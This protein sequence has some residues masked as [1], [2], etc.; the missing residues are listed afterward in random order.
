MGY[1]GGLP[2]PNK[3]RYLI[4]L[5]IQYRFVRCG[6]VNQRDWPRKLRLIRKEG[7]E[8]LFSHKVLHKLKNWQQEMVLRL[9]STKRNSRIRIQFIQ[10][11]ACF[12]GF[13]KTI[14]KQFETHQ[15]LQIKS[16]LPGWCNQN[17]TVSRI[18]AHRKNCIFTPFKAIYWLWPMQMKWVLML[19]T[20]RNKDEI[21]RNESLRLYLL[22]SHISTWAPTVAKRLPSHW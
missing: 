20:H 21:S 13:H 2:L 4:L 12:P 6:H 11:I 9:P 14:T 15:N 18:K 7:T 8:I 17:I 10:V 19:I 22:G 16:N 5:L 3:Q 1:C